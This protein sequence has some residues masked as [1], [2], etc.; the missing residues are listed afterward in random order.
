MTVFINQKGQE[1]REI[2][3][4][5]KGKVQQIENLQR[6]VAETSEEKKSLLFKIK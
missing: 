5:L 6:I 4:E 2:K 1:N 3:E